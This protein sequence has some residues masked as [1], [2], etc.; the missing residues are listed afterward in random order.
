MK[1]EIDEGIRIHPLPYAADIA[2]AIRD[3]DVSYFT[4][5]EKLER[6]Y[7]NAWDMGFKV[8]F[9]AIPK[10][11]GVRKLNVPP[12]FRDT[13]E[14]YPIIGNDELVEYLKLKIS[15]GKADIMQHGFCHAEDPNLPMP[16]FDFEKGIISNSESHKMN[17]KQSS[18]FYGLKG[19]EVYL[20]VK[21]GKSILENAFGVPIKVFVAPQE[22]LTKS[23]WM[24]LLKNSL[25]YCGGIGRNIIKQVPINHINFSMVL[26]V[27]LKKKFR[28]NPE[29]IAEDV[30]RITDIIIVPAT[31]RHYWNKFTNDELS[32]YWFNQFKMIFEDKKKQNGYFILLTHYWEYFYD[33][34]EEITQKRQYKYLYKILRYVDGSL[35]VWKCT[36]SELVDW[37]MAR[38]NLV[39]KERNRR[40][41]IFSPCEIKGLSISADG[42]NTKD[43]PSENIIISDDGKYIVLNM[44]KGKKVSLLVK[45]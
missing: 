11:K 23:L 19:E 44:N 24:A 43:V 10:H 14:Y 27:A 13:N 6:I 7:R 20:R 21:A 12:K 16:K 40:F 18:E 42:I 5:P 34:E 1:S 45:R 8:S 33:W 22:L 39:V 3:D 15:E 25:N 36:I 37:I 38:N 4:S 32:E 31:Y 30:T 2:F 28:V 29:S 17:S 41:E 26:K 9:A 35:N